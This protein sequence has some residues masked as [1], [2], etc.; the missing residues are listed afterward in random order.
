M[1]GP[2][3]LTAQGRWR[4]LCAYGRLMVIGGLFGTL[5]ADS[6]APT[7]DEILARLESETNRRHDQLKEY[8]GSR[9]YTLQNSRFGKRA[10]VDVL[11]KYRQV[12]GER[13]TVLRSEEHTSELQS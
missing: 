9:Q 12:D 3:R 6:V 2:S 7:S 13:Y 1:T 5:T 4:R 11:M 8:S 10:A